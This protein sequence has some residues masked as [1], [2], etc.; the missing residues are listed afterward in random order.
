MS[1]F[2][3]LPAKPLNHAERTRIRTRDD[4]DGFI[5]LGTSSIHRRRGEREQNATEAVMLVDRTLYALEYDD[6]EWSTEVLQRNA[7]RQ[8]H[9]QQALDRSDEQTA[10][11]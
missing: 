10:R 5:V 7:D 8:D 3:M 11:K 1:V 9:L 6:S 4:V 2:S